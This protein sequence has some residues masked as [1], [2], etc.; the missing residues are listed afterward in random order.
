MSMAAVPP[1]KDRRMSKVSLP[2][3]ILAAIIALLQATVVPPSVIEMVTTHFERKYKKEKE[4]EDEQHLRL[5]R[6]KGKKK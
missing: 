1:R 3:R 6:K 2:V 4:F 5:L